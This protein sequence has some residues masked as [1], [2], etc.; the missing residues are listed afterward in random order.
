MPSNRD[1]KIKVCY[2]D[3]ETGEGLSADPCPQKA[4]S[5]GICDDKTRRSLTQLERI[6]RR[7]QRRNPNKKVV[8]RFRILNA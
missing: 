3:A 4:D 6:I 1:S 2:F 8:N 7:R 5:H